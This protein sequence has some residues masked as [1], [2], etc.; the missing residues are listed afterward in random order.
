[1]SS[2]PKYYFQD[3]PSYVM[4]EVVEGMIQGRPE[5]TCEEMDEW[6][7]AQLECRAE[8]LLAQHC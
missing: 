4:D 6:L 7:N 5:P 2:L 3:I 8:A 1:M